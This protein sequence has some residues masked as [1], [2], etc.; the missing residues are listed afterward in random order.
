[1]SKEKSIPAAQ[2][3]YSH[4]TVHAVL[5][6]AGQLCHP[7][8]TIAC[9]CGLHDSQMLWLP[10]MLLNILVFLWL[11]VAAVLHD[12]LTVRLAEAHAL[13]PCFIFKLLQAC[14]YKI[15]VVA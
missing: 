4:C 10:L 11:F 8:G 15:G 14:C 12:D 5:P 1:M 3:A 2:H 13:H 6:A 9:Q 7:S